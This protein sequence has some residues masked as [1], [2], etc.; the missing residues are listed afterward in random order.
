MENARCEIRTSST[1]MPDFLASSVR[2]EKRVTQRWKIGKIFL[3]SLHRRSRSHIVYTYHIYIISILV[4]LEYFHVTT[5]TGNANT[6]KRA[7]TYPTA[8]ASLCRLTF[9]KSIQCNHHSPHM[10]P[11]LTQYLHSSS[12]ERD[13]SAAT[14]AWRR[15]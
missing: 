14:A 2:N 4:W 9:A 15:T 12:T 5:I 8:P 6:G 3:A 13:A 11:P 7:I 10:Q 1:N